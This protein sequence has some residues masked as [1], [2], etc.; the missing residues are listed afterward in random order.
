MP[1][2]PQSK[3]WTSFKTLL[4]IKKLSSKLLWGIVSS[5]GFRVIEGIWEYDC[6]NCISLHIP[7]VVRGCLM[8][9]K[10]LEKTHPQFLTS[11]CVFLTQPFVE[12]M[13]FDKLLTLIGVEQRYWD[14]L[15]QWCCPRDPLPRL[16]WGP[17]R[18]VKF[19][20]KV[21]QTYIHYVFQY[22][23]EFW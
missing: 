2:P 16:P 3:E 9:A 5:P 11:F 12:R 1:L 13:C 21:L 6:C 7:N 22:L 17:L 10:I 8:R 14:L 19:S 15:W 20:P 23:F 18:P 4:Q